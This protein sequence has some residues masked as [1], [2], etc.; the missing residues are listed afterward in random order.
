MKNYRVLLMM[1]LF[2]ALLLL[3]SGCSTFGVQPQIKAEVVMKTGNVLLLFHGGTQTA[4]SLFCPGE[5]VA[6]YR[7]CPQERLRYVE[8]GKVKITRYLD[9]LHV[10][11]VVVS[12]EVMEGDLAMKAKAACIVA[13]NAPEEK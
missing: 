8:V 2:L 5:T 10:E 1:T 3:F 7:A 12:G 6:V 9:D 13:P 4:K 11:A